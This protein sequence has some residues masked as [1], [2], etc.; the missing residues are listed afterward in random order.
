MVLAGDIFVGRERELDRLRAHRQ[1]ETGGIL[2]VI[3]PA[4]IGKTRLVEEYLERLDDT[5]AARFVSLVEVADS[6]QVLARTLNVLGAHVTGLGDV[7]RMCHQLSLLEEDGAV[8]VFDNA[9]H[10]LEHVTPIANRLA[11]LDQVQ[12]IVTSREPLG[13]PT[14]TVLRLETLTTAE[15]IM[16]L[17]DLARCSGTPLSDPDAEALSMALDGLP[18]AL[19]LASA[20]TKILSP[21]Q[22][23]ERLRTS[24]RVLS[25]AHAD[26]HASLDIALSQSWI[27]LTFE[28]QQLAIGLSA[29]AHELAEEVAVALWS[30]LGVTEVGKRLVACSWLAMSDRDGAPC[31]QML[32]V[33]RNYVRDQT[34]DADCLS[35]ERRIVEWAL[36]RLERTPTWDRVVPEALI[37]VDTMCAHKDLVGAGRVLLSLSTSAAA[38]QH[39]QS[40]ATVAAE[41]ADALCATGDAG[42]HRELCSQLSMLVARSYFRCLGSQ[43]PI[44]WSQRAID[45]A[46]NLSFRVRALSLLSMSWMS[47]N[48][49]DR[50]KRFAL[51]AWHTIQTDL[52]RDHHETKGSAELAMSTLN[53]SV[54]FNGLGHYA[55]AHRTIALSRELARDHFASDAFASHQ[56]RC[57]TYE[58]YVFFGEGLFNE[59][60]NTISNAVE[61]LKNAPTPERQQTLHIAIYMALVRRS[62]GEAQDL[63]SEFGA[64]AQANQAA[65][66]MYFHA[67]AAAEL[68]M[69]EDESPLPHLHR[70]YY[71]HALPTGTSSII[72]EGWLMLTLAEIGEGNNEVAR[73]RLARLLEDEEARPSG[74]TEKYRQMLRAAHRFASRNEFGTDLEAPPKGTNAFEDVIDLALEAIDSRQ[75]GK[76]EAFFANFDPSLLS[77][78]G[79]VTFRFEHHVLRWVR[80]QRSRRQ[81]VVLRIEHDGRR[82][83][84]EG[85]PCDLSRKGTVRRMLLHLAR[86]AE[87]SPGEFTS[88]ETL[89]RAVWPEIKTID[90]S[91]LNRAYATI[92]RLRHSTELGPYLLGDKRGY[93]FRDRLRLEWVDTL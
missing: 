48:D 79:F 39:A 28:E 77:V 20:R 6:A 66:R 49:Y 29:L 67:V 41:V 31:F 63:L 56:A 10:L 33:V 40:I 14:E 76:I 7:E 70:A 3:G 15:G 61:F 12:I 91:A 85:R 23:Q 62:F 71:R 60:A 22:I 27:R 75:D 21:E 68:A 51:D 53:L 38:G 84:F 2:T 57:S 42:E 37:A 81:S 73:T 24:N 8:I 80:A 5:W 4:G 9:E 69:L 59:C 44:Y 13:I 26:H 52:P 50:A 47:I 35:N 78:P 36:E 82:F 88:V 64:F 89:I 18:L 16:L 87:V 45:L 32:S 19:R 92:N 93:R 11:E 90:T 58:A 83:E 46:P 74:Y 1:S 55:T 86:A 65:P 17:Q 72:S 30:Q 54:V 34:S 25:T 43:D